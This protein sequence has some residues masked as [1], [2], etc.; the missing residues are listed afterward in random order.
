MIAS[1]LRAKVVLVL[2]PLAVVPAAA[3]VAWLRDANR[4][5]V[6][7]SE[8]LM[9]VALLGEVRER[10]RDEIGAQR[11]HRAALAIIVCSATICRGMVA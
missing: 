9:Q 7:E 6:V 11:G 8:R 3:A 2:V 1:S 5:A 4:T 10:A